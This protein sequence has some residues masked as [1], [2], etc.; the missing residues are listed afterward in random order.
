MSADSQQP[1]V[2]MIQDEGVH[3]VIRR[4]RIIQALL[5]LGLSVLILIAAVGVL[6]GLKRS[7]I[8]LGVFIFPAI[9]ALVALVVGLSLVGVFAKRAKRTEAFEAAGRLYG[10]G[11]STAGGIN[12]AA[13]CFTVSALFRNGADEGLWVPAVL[14]LVINALGV[15]L[16]VPA[17]K[18]LRRL[19]YTPSL[20]V[21][22]V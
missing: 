6:T 17:I 14:L 3:R 20:P 19:F 8:G 9:W 1:V 15:I 10:T 2:P 5:I 12:L 13:G 11:C 22:R 18:Q 7:S 21:A 16:A 4:M